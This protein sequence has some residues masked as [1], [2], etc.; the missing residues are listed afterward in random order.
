VASAAAVDSGGRGAGRRARCACS[1]RAC[2]C[3]RVAAGSCLRFWKAA[4][5]ASAHGQSCCRRSLPRR[6]EKVRRAATCSSRWPCRGRHGYRILHLAG[7]LTATPAATPC[8]S[9]PTGPGLAR[10]S[11]RSNASKHC[12]RTPDRSRGPARQPH[13]G[14]RRSPLLKTGHYKSPR[15]SIVPLRPH[16]PA[17]RASATTPTPAPRRLRSYSTVTDESRLAQAPC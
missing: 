7:H 14:D 12:P 17:D 1:W 13:S 4:R 11:E 10:P 16:T 9:P 3:Q 2:W 15:R 6:P 8:T 5:S